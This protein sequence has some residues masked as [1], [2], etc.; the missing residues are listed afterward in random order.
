MPHS[1]SP[2]ISGAF[3]VLW[4]ISTFFLLLSVVGIQTSGLGIYRRP[5]AVSLCAV[6][7]MAGLFHVLL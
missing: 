6:L 3:F 7:I 2:S 1:T 4:L 5:A